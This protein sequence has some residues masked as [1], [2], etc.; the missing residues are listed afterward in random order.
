LKSYILEILEIFQILGGKKNVAG[1]IHQV[2]SDSQDQSKKENAFRTT[3]IL[4]I[5]SDSFI[6]TVCFSHGRKPFFFFSS[7]LGILFPLDHQI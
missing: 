7:P 4:V 3:L 5:V 6:V 2:Y 1:I